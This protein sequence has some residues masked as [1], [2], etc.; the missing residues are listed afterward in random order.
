MMG[1]LV[2]WW[3]GRR[4]KYVRLTLDHGDAWMAACTCGWRAT[5]S[6]WSQ[7]STRRDWQEHVEREA[8]SWT[9]T[10]SR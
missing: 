9:T 10:R 7:H 3:V 8:S 5:Y 1:R 2:R 4:H 6:H